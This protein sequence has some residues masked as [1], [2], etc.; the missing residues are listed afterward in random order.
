M[1]D[2]IYAL[3]TKSAN[4]VAS[5]VGEALSGTE[6]E[7]GK[8]M[9]R[10]ARALGMSATT[11]RNASGLTHSKQRTTARDMARLAIA[12]RRDFPQYFGFFSTKSFRWRGKRFGN[13]VE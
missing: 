11:F 13:S 3:I 6:R 9:T 2:A 8:R 12:M 10:K 7:F 1:K 5:V 4:D